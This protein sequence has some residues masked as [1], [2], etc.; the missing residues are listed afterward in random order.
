MLGLF[1]DLFTEDLPWDENRASS[2]FVFL[3]QFPEKIKP[4][5]KI[6]VDI[7]LS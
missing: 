3:F 2:G 7:V 4:Q 5:Y 6:A 1:H